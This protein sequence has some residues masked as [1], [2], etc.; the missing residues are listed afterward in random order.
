[1]TEMTDTVTEAGVPAAESPVD[2]TEPGT[3]PE[4][5]NGGDSDAQDAGEDAGEDPD[6]DAGDPRNREA[7]KWRV[8]Y[9]E[10]EAAIAAER[11]QWTLERGLLTAQID[12]M[13][14]G[15]V[16]R[17]AAGLLADPA[18]VWRDGTDL[19]QLRDADGNVDA[20]KVTAAVK[21]LAAAHPH[22]LR[23]RRPASDGLRS[24]ASGKQFTEPVSWR[25]AFTPAD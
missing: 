20:R 11:E 17:I 1:M 4:D 18:D 25:D 10:A 13:Q 5:T 22:W 9:R 21:A 16:E 15:E 7:A 12:L 14:R 2:A 23:P 24:G 8:K 19:D 6:D 3:S